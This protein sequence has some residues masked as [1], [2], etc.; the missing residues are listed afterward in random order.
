MLSLSFLLGPIPGCMADI[1]TGAGGEHI[2]KNTTSQTR[3]KGA[4]VS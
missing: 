4:A 1:S 3:K 2:E